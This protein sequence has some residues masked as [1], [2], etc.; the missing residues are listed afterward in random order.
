MNKKTRN[1]IITDFFRKLHLHQ[2]KINKLPD[3][4]QDEL[5]YLIIEKIDL[6]IELATD[7]DFNEDQCV[8]MSLPDQVL[9]NF[10]NFDI[11]LKE[12]N[13][14][15]LIEKSSKNVLY[16]LKE[17]IMLSRKEQEEFFSELLN[18]ACIKQD[19]IIYH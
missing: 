18:E 16:Y 19:K 11:F 5:K 15:P 17:M 1:E 6:Y 14:N 12:I 8:A 13:L 9:V 4:D 2:E 3:E 10:L 7:L